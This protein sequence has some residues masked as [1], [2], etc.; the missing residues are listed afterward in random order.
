LA[1]DRTLISIRERRQIDLFDLALVVIR[2]RPW[3]LASAALCGMIPFLVLNAWLFPLFGTAGPGI[4]LFLWWIEAPMASAPLTLV[5]GSLMFG[6]MAPPRVVARQLAASFGTLAMT[7]GLLRFVPVYWLPPRLVFGN[8]V[9]LL[10]RAG[11]L[12]L[13]KRGGNLAGGREGDLVILSIAQFGATLIFATLGYVGLGRLLQSVTAEKLTWDLPEATIL[14]TL[15]FQI[16]I[17]VGVAYFTV[18]RFLTY[19]DQRIRLEGWEVELRVRT[20][21]E[22][23]AEARRW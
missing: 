11:W 1:I 21:G 10:E 20:A 9:V 16:P 22:A 17:W 3:P 19:I 6:R 2:R 18:V 13:W 12:T 23:L 5:L 14:T 4:S 15:A 8:E 7:H